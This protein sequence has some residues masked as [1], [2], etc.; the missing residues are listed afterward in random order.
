MAVK[1]DTNRTPRFLFTAP[2]E[3][4]VVRR[5]DAL[6]LRALT[7]TFAEA[8][9][10]GLS[11]R[12]N[13]GRWVTILA[14][15]LVHSQEVFHASGGRA[16]ATRAEQQERY[17]WLRP[18]E[19]MWV[20]RTRILAE[21]DFRDRPLA[22]RRRVVRWYE[23]DGMRTERFGMTE[24]QFRAYRQT[25]MYGGYRLAFRRWAGMTSR[26]DG[27][28]P[29]KATFYLAKW[30]EAKLGVAR[31]PLH[32]DEEDGGVSTRSAKMS[33]RKEA[34]WWLRQWEGFDKGGRNFDVNTLPRLRLDFAKLPEA[35]L[36]EGIIFGGDE[37][38]K[39]RRDVAKT[40]ANSRAQ[41]HLEICE[42]LSHK[43]AD[44][45]TIKLLPLFSRL[46]DAG[47]E[48]MDFI[49]RSLVTSDKP[50]VPLKNIASAPEAKG[51]CKKLFQAAS[52]WKRNH[53]GLQL[54]HIGS[55]HRFANAFQT[56]DPYG[57]LSALLDHHEFSGGGLRWFVLRNG[58]VEPRST[59]QGRASSRYRFRFWPLCRLAAQCGVVL[60]SIK[61]KFESADEEMEDANE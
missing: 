40:I 59:P 37:Q 55:A 41:S 10:P 38:G 28:T 42:H 34:D 29:G 36:L 32:T 26:G 8:V 35:D 30:L 17:A 5:G 58:N 39:R 20:A 51:L 9:A 54:R 50:T 1:D 45:E 57:C 11:N 46:A 25:G 14:W 19:L 18:L 53:G 21:D 27:W 12:T 31:L 56:D 6:G 22:G 49:A 7:D 47:I 24:D 48:A 16:V 43:F 4:V 15:C 2:W 52:S 61:G 60:P 33:K 3:P 23:D 13:D 44:N